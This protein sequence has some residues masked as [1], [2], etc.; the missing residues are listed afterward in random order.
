MAM[1]EGGQ[2]QSGERGQGLIER[3][4]EQRE[5]HKGRSKVIR[6]LYL[7]AGFTVLLA[8]IVMTG[9]VPGPGI[10]VIPI[11]LAM[12][13]LEFVWAEHLLEKAMDRAE[14]AKRKAADTT[15]VQRILSGLAIACGIGAFVA[16]A[17]MWDIPLLPV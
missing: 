8:G 11:G 14:A 12:L 1:P 2:E 16:A 10:L 15:R 7:V 3:I 17:V 5:R 4:R 6:G 13:A 9:P